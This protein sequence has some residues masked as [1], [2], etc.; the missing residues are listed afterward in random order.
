[1]LFGC[2]GG[3]GEKK[4]IRGFNR[5]T[6]AVRQTGSAG[7]P[8]SVILPSIDKKIITPS[9]ILNDSLTKFDD[10]SEERLLTYKL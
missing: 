8:I 7:K 10:G 6:Q 9:T 3:L 2:V 4:H 5:A 1:M